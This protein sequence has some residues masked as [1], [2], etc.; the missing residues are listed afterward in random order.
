M[1]APLP[2]TSLTSTDA[3]PQSWVERIFD[4]MLAT[5]GKKFI[6][7]W[8]GVDPEKLQA[9][10]AAKL[11]GFSTA[12]LKRGV[13]ALEKQTFCPTLPE[14]MK[15]CRPPI[16]PLAAYYEAV[17]GI[18]VRERGEVGTWSHPAIFW[19]SVAIGAHDLKNSTYSQIKPRWENA[20]RAEIDN[21][22]WVDIPAPVLSL[23]APSKREIDM[24]VAAKVLDGLKDMTGSG[25]N[26]YR[27]WARKIL[28]RVANGERPPVAVVKM[29]KEALQAKEFTE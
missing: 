8:V 12:E 18:A 7:Q 1:N 23:P 26:E 22:K 28:Q 19:A 9:H 14:F 16:D 15:L 20:L 6:D 13:D 5:F 10:W 3:L 27:N 11:A 25:K 21:G 17:E 2:T 24:V 29:A 4:V